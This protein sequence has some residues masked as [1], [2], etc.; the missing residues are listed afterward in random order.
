MTE[1]KEVFLQRDEA[2]VIE[3]LEVNNLQS[4]DIYNF[5]TLTY[6]LQTSEENQKQIAFEIYTIRSVWLNAFKPIIINQLKKYYQRGRLDLG[7]YSDSDLTLETPYSLLNTYMNSTYRSDMIRRNDVWNQLTEYLSQLK[8]TQKTGTIIELIDRVNNVTHNA[9][10]TILSK[11]SNC[12]MLIQALDN[13]HKSNN[14]KQF[15]L[16]TSGIDYLL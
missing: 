10:T 12:Q 5:Y 3:F 8:A 9:G 1:K 13:C 6:L 16:K 7:S 2:E 15:R 4:S 14:P 11:F